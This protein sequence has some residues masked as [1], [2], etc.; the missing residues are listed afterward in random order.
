M[1]LKSTRACHQHNMKV[2][3]SCLQMSGHWSPPSVLH[4][5]L[6]QKPHDNNHTN[7]LSP[8]VSLYCPQLMRMAQQTRNWP[9]SLAT[10]QPSL[11]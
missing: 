3:H 9:T 10:C 6:E 1:I 11:M 8:I 7:I 4:S 2:W 5:L